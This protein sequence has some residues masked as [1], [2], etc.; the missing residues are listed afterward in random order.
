[1]KRFLFI[2]V[3]AV[4]LVAISPISPLPNPVGAQPDEALGV[5]GAVNCNTCV[6]AATL[7]ASPLDPL[8][9]FQSFLLHGGYVAAGTAMRNR[10]FGTISVSGIPK[11][12]SIKAAYLYWDILGNLPYSSF[13]Q[14]QIN[15]NPITGTLIGIDADPCWGNTNNFAYRADVTSIVRTNGD[16]SLTNFASGTTNGQDPWGAGSALPMI[17]G[18]SLVIVYDNSRSPWTQVIIY[19]GSIETDWYL[20]SQTIDGFTAPSPVTKALITFIG[21]DGQDAGEPGS[22]FNG[23]PLTSISWDG[24]DTQ[25]GLSYSHGNLWDTMTAD[26][27]SLVYPGDTSATATVQGGPDCLVWVALIFSV[28]GDALSFPWVEKPGQV[29]WSD[30]IEINAGDSAES[31]VVFKGNVYDPAKSRVKLQIELR[32]LDEFGGSFTG[33]FT[34]QSDLVGSGKEASITVYGLIPGQYHWRY[35]VVD[36]TDNTAPWVSFGGN[37][38]SGVDFRVLLQGLDVSHWQESIDWTA[39]AQAG[40]CFALV[41]ATQGNTIQDPNFKDNWDKAKGA[42]LAVGAYHFAT[43]KKHPGVE[44]AEAEAQWFYNSVKTSVGGFSGSLPPILDVEDIG[45]GGL[46]K[47]V[48]TDWVKAFFDKLENLAGNDGVEL[49]RVIIYSNVCFLNDNLDLSQFTDDFYLFWVGRVGVSALSAPSKYSC[50]V[51]DTS[52]TFWQ[53]LADNANKQKDKVLVPGIG[54]NIKVDLDLFSGSTEELNGLIIP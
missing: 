45:S 20:V 31:T 38:D 54:N 39:V 11:G 28:Q 23:N 51:W 32:R 41:K 15:G 24:N 47:K 16:Y 4:L 25:A 21:A 30:N 19:D 17:E 12:S 10:G 29:R 8:Q 42:G 3:G 40:Y 18:A 13:A 43:A 50:A 14:G 9:Y 27:T 7:S 37:P 5:A 52:W 1:M 34:Q 44:G 2:M 46:D 35:R 48:L 26:V 36:E 53:Y 22:M 49:P 6:S 33:E